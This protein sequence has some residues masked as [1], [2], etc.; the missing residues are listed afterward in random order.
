[1]SSAEYEWMKSAFVG[2]YSYTRIQPD[3]A[4]G[5]LYGYF[6]SAFPCGNEIGYDGKIT[7][8]SRVASAR[9]G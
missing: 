6:T 9:G 8:P 4:T 5:L 7:H 2:A 1:M 3:A